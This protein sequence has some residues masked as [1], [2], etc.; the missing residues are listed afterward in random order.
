MRIHD[1]RTLGSK[2][3][4]VQFFNYS[5]RHFLLV[6]GM[7]SAPVV[8]TLDNSSFFPETKLSANVLPKEKLGQVINATFDYEINKVILQTVAQNGNKIIYEWNPF[9]FELLD[10][11]KTINRVK[12]KN[13]DE[14]FKM[15]KRMNDPKIKIY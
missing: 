11:L 12:S 3:T 2:I 5:N 14:Y 10:K 4:A 13:S 8:C 7:R 9:S 15:V 6:T 1:L